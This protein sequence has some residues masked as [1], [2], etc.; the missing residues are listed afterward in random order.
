MVGLN[1]HRGIVRKVSQGGIDTIADTSDPRYRSVSCD[2]VE[3]YRKELRQLTGGHDTPYAFVRFCEAQMLWDSA[4]AWSLVDHAEANPGV[5]TVVLAGIF[6]TWKYGIPER[7][8][9]QSSL[10]FRVIL[11]SEQQAPFGFDIT[12]LE[13]DYVWWFGA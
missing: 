2:P 12:S 10:S 11:P 8:Q 9:Q 3:R 13:A 5:T 4:M 7:V 6:H 1:I